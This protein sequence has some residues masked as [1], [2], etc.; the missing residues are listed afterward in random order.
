MKCVKKTSEKIYEEA[1]ESLKEAKYDR[2]IGSLIKCKR[3]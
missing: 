3:Q 2:T 1:K